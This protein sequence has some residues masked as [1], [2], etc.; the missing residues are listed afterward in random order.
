MSIGFNEYKANGDFLMLFHL[1]RLMVWSMA[2]LVALASSAM[3][4]ADGFVVKESKPVG[5]IL[6]PADASEVVKFAAKE[7]MDHIKAM[8]GAALVT[9][10]DAGGALPEGAIRLALAA[11]APK[12]L[13][14]DGS[15]EYCSLDQTGK[16]VFIEGRSDIAVLYG[17]YEYLNGLGVRWFI[18]GEIG[19]QVPKRASIAL[20]GKKKDVKPGFRI[21]WIWLDG[22]PDWHLNGKTPEALSAQLIDEQTWRLRN[23]LNITTRKSKTPLPFPLNIG[24]THDNF[25]HNIQVVLRWTKADFKKSPERFPLVIK[26][27]GTAERLAKGGQI[28]FTNKENI[29]SGIAW[30]LDYFAKNP[31]QI[32]A[33]FSLQD[34]GGVCQ[35]DQ[36]VK[37]NDGKDTSLDCNALVWDYMNKVAAGIKKERPDRGIAF[38]S[39]YGAMTCPPDGIKAQGNMLGVVCHIDGNNRELDDTND[40]VNV[41]FVESIKKLQS[42]GAQVCSYDYT[43]FMPSPQPLQIASNVPKYHKLGLIGYSTEIMAKSEHHVMVNWIQA[44]L[45]WN[46]SLD[47]RKLIEEYCNTYFGAAGPDVLAVVDI[48]EAS[49][50]KIPKIT[51]SGFGTAQEM[52]TEEVISACRARFAQAAT[53]VNGVEA[54]RLARMSDTIEFYSLLAQAYRALYIAIDDRT[55]ENQA[56]AIASFDAAQA[57]WDKNNVSRCCSPRIPEAW[58]ARVKKSAVNLQPIAA[59]PTKTLAGADEAT[60]LKELFALYEVPA[61]K[62]E[63]LTWLPDQWKFK[64]DIFNKGKEQG[65]MAP[66]FDDSKWAS[67][68]YNFFDNQG[69]MRIEGTF[70]YRTAFAAPALA[71][72]KRMIMRIGALDDDGTIYINGKPA[73]TRVHLDGRDWERSFEFDITDFVKPGAK[74]SVAICGRNDYGKGGLWRPVAVYTR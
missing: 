35:C 22:N 63:N 41:R 33:S 70:W 69:F 54:Q 60:K 39:T 38:F 58:I 17:A 31:D 45:C 50:Q 14:G 11:D 68:A 21:R 71:P 52:M 44:Q 62:L 65:W 1:P 32:T 5:Q 73:F 6:I 61:A 26:L 9:A 18:P 16:G 66:G 56:R 8:T 53:K 59:A 42:T 12:I 46:P 28:C 3:A 7:L 64:P 29:D 74:N 57:F 37:A 20:D 15:E 43:T 2:L 55:P 72:G 48:I 25:S 4:W 47:P 34:T 30:A 49:S 19:T 23:R 36:C 10:T 67:L 51:L 24:T 13:P 27:D 40:Q